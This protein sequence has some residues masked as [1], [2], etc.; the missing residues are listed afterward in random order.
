ME[1][2]TDVLPKNVYQVYVN[3][4]HPEDSAIYARAITER[5]ELTTVLGEPIT[6]YKVD[7]FIPLNSYDSTQYFTAADLDND[8][9]WTKSDPTVGATGLL[10]DESTTYQYLT[11]DKDK[12]IRKYEEFLNK[13]RQICLERIE[14]NKRL[15]DFYEEKIRI[16]KIYQGDM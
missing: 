7:T 15:L 10:M 1:N 6:R 3:D 16:F 4:A 12:A 8:V 9:E 14:W 5:A 2:K 11:L 13:V